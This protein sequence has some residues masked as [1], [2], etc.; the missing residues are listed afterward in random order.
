MS[1][2]F[3]HQYA[4]LGTVRLHCVTAGQGRLIIFL[5]G[6]PEFWYEWKDQL[7]E[8]G[9]NYQAVAPDMRGYNLSSR[10]AEVEQ[11]RMKYLI[12][13]IRLLAEHLGHKKFFLVGHDWGGS[14]AWAFALRHP[15]YLEKLV[16]INAPH[17]LVF[18]REL[19]QNPA[20]RKAS[21]YILMQRSPEAEQ[22]ISADSFSL[23]VRSVLGERLRQGYLDQDD[24]KAYLEAWSR[25]G[26][27]TGSL[28]YYRAM[29]VEALTGEEDKAAGDLARDAALLTVKVPTLVIWGEKDRY[30]LTGNLDGLE[31][32][33]PELTVKRIPDASHWVVH[34]KPALV[35]SYIRDF[36]ENRH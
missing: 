10:P 8:F 15:E 1:V 26:A 34:E 36:I 22:I 31:E 2:E 28:N 5:H 17:P 16:I 18:E 20:Q 19:R 29:R 25:P 12:E 32:Y 13:D 21:Q 27:L 7:K 6:F 4:E 33:V 11:Y 9:R 3:K 14:V 24:L 23:L 30:L 35:N